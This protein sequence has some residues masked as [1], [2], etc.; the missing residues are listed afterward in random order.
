MQNSLN[1]LKSKKNDTSNR[2]KSVKKP[3]IRLK[4]KREITNKENKAKKDTII[5]QSS[6]N[7]KKPLFL[8]TD[9]KIFLLLKR[10]Y[11]MRELDKTEKFVNSE[12]FKEKQID[13]TNDEFKR[14]VSEFNN[15]LNL[16]KLYINFEDLFKSLQ[17]QNKI[18]NI[19]KIYIINKIEEK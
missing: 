18:I 4:A 6:I 19:L 11:Y 2:K 16:Q 8:Y 17:L 1:A 13:L 7:D 5:E 15:L 14:L 10:T 12:R 3:K 9:K